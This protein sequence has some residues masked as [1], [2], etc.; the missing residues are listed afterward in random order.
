VGR[1]GHSLSAAREQMADREPDLCLEMINPNC[2]PLE[3]A[4]QRVVFSKAQNLYA[5]C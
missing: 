5:E 4:K 2:L 1:I 3:E